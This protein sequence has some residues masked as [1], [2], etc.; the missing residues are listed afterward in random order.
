MRMLKDMRNCTTAM[1]TLH[2]SLIEN[3]EVSAV[4]SIAPETPTH[5]CIRGK[6]ISNPRFGLSLSIPPDACGN[7]GE[8]HPSTLETALLR[9]SEN[10]DIDT[11]KLAYIDSLGYSDICRFAN[12]EEL[13]EEMK[14]LSSLLSEFRED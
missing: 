11:A 6:I 12:I 8:R 10:G 1:A 3:P 4:I 13:V 9:I 2:S 14:R 7:R 5:Y